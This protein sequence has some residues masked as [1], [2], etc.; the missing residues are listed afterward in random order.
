[1]LKTET[2]MTMSNKA[3]STDSL[4]QETRTF[5]PPPEILKRAHLNAAQYQCPL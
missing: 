1:M 4:L 2:R 5:P 3:I